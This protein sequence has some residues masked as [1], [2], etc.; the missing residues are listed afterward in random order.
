MTWAGQK[1]LAN[2]GFFTLQAHW[3]ARTRTWNLLIQSQT[4]Y[5]LHHSP[6]SAQK[7]RKQAVGRRWCGSYAIRRNPS[8]AFRRFMEH[9]GEPKPLGR[10]GLPTAAA[11]DGRHTDTELALEFTPRVQQDADGAVVYRTDLH[12]VTERAALNVKVQPAQFITESLVEHDRALG[13]RGR[14]EGRTPAASCVRLD[15]KGADHQNRTVHLPYIVVHAVAFVWKDPQVPHRV[16]EIR[17]VLVGVI[18]VLT[19]AALVRSARRSQ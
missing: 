5:Q 11:G 18:C 8:T 2:T 6:P 12:V 10:C 16:G 15:R 4:C 9:S 1:I 14:R 7:P 17:S 13:R 3:A 19:R